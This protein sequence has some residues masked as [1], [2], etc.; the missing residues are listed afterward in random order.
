MEDNWTE[1]ERFRTPNGILFFLNGKVV[2]GVLNCV[3]VMLVCFAKRI[4]F[5]VLEIDRFQSCG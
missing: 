2:L 1:K 5:K 4:I 3:C